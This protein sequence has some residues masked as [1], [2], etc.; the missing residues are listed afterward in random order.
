VAI[1][2]IKHKGL[3]EL[4]Q[5][6]RTRLVSKNYFENALLIMDHLDNIAGLEDCAGVKKFHPLKGG[7][8]GEYAM[9][10]SGNWRIT[11]TCQK[12]NNETAVT[13]L[14]LEDYH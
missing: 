1:V 6:G 12:L 5:N 7:R 8:K 11:F 14:G 4:F 3:R 13:I 2:K 9:S 10:V